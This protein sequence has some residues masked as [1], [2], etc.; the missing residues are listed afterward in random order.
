MCQY[1]TANKRSLQNHISNFHRSKL[2]K[3]KYCEKKFSFK[4]QVQKHI[5]KEHSRKL[6]KCPYCSYQKSCIGQ[7]MQRHISQRHGMR[8]YQAKDLNKS[9]SLK[10]ITKGLYKCDKCSYSSRNLELMT[11]HIQMHSLK[12]VLR[13]LHCY[14]MANDVKKYKIH[15]MN[16]HKLAK[17]VFVCKK[18]FFQSEDWKKHSEHI[19]R[20]HQSKLSSLC[21]VR[22]ENTKLNYAHSSDNIKKEKFFGICSRNDMISHEMNDFEGL[23]DNNIRIKEE[24]DT[25]ELD[26]MNRKESGE[27]VNSDND[28][29]GT[30]NPIEFE[31]VECIDIND[32]CDVNP[33][34]INVSVSKKEPCELEHD[35][36]SLNEMIFN[37][38][39]THVTIHL[40]FP[41]LNVEGQGG[42]ASANNENSE[43]LVENNSNFLVC[44]FCDFR[45][46]G[47]LNMKNHLK[48]EHLDIFQGL[49]DFLDVSEQTIAYVIKEEFEKK[50]CCKLCSHITVELSSLKSHFKQEHIMKNLK[51][52]RCLLDGFLNLRS[53]W[54][55][56]N[57][58]CPHCQLWFKEGLQ[59]HILTHV[60][61]Y[62][63]NSTQLFTQIAELCS[64]RSNKNRIRKL[65][66]CKPI[67]EHSF[68]IAKES[69][70]AKLWKNTFEI[71]N[72]YQVEHN[73]HTGSIKNE[74]YLGEYPEDDDV[75]SCE[76]IRIIIDDENHCTSNLN[77]S[78]TK[79]KVHAEK[80]RGDGF[81]KNKLKKLDIIKKK[82]TSEKTN[83]GYESTDSNNSDCMSEKQFS[84]KPFGIR[85]IRN[86]AEKPVR[87]IK[88]L[89]NQCFD[90][91]NVY[92]SRYIL[93][94]HRKKF[95]RLKKPHSCTY[96]IEI[97]ETYNKLKSHYYC[98]HKVTYHHKGPIFKCPLCDY[99]CIFLK[100]MK[101]HVL[102]IHDRNAVGFKK[103]HGI[104]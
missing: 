56:I 78:P 97:F 76:E 21:D 33:I 39:E 80:V 13:C 68:S 101:N 1:A 94:D 54:D 25:G 70:R 103:R 43:H 87:M 96:C 65:P 3:C 30:G 81:H 31:E 57:E 9:K 44:P 42:S 69:A 4:A 26:S 95:H 99:S 49:K 59:S 28:L 23:T 7:V 62:K 85:S 47:Q 91:L 14:F 48:F 45:I 53:F 63:N 102:E 61:Q 35:F 67:N 100:Q 72:E 27:I 34:P 50:Y 32:S 98:E 22:T 92:K 60:P 79:Q 71:D 36:L 5:R 6:R 38:Y 18:C 64:K 29:P 58:H 75:D 73:L 2:H 89:E 17:E 51:C 11:F 90:C 16:A 15:L 40:R 84:L 10:R 24:L 41:N 93:V 88:I 77:L 37:E 12:Y 86:I 104:C 74:V 66:Q 19:C 82:I 8:E 46:E 20:P 83:S 52:S 55:H